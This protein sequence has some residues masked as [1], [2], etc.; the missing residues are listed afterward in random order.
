[1]LRTISILAVIGLTSTAARA[2]DDLYYTPGPTFAPEASYIY[3]WSGTRVGFHGGFAW[4]EA[5]SDFALTTGGGGTFSFDQDGGEVGVHVGHNWQIGTIVL[6]LGAEATWLDIEGSSGV[7]GGAL[8]SLDTNFLFNATARA[9]V[10][11]DHY[12][13]YLLGGLSVLDYDY[14][15]SDPASPASENHDDSAFGGTLGAG[16][17]IAVSNEVSLFGEYRHY[18]FDGDSNTFAGPGGVTTQSVD[19]EIDIDTVS[20]G[21]N[22]RF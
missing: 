12:Q 3:D 13:P 9:G 10:A 4:G 8:H 7:A 15:L 1:M 17:E 22:W 14:T 20:G 19:P 5:E 11:I 16:V 21:I 2:A 18:W 6:G